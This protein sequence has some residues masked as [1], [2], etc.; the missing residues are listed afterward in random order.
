[1]AN[2]SFQE[3]QRLRSIWWPTGGETVVGK[4]GCLEIIIIF[5]CG[6]MGTL[7]WAMA[8][9]GDGRIQKYNLAVAEGVRLLKTTYE[10]E[11]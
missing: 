10:K 3:G 11:S 6:Q 1:M 2:D 9:F 7:P 4:N 8:T 5:E